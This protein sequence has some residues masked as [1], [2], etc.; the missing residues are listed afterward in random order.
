MEGFG[1]KKSKNKKIKNLKADN[2][3]EQIIYKAFKFHSEGNISE[4][5]KYYQSFIK[6][7][8][9]DFR[10]FSNYGFILIGLG[11]F[12]EA[13]LLLRK[14]IELKPDYAEAHLNLGNILQG[15]G[16]FKE[17]A[18][19]TH[20]A[21][22]LKPDFVIAYLN[23]GNILK[24]LGQLEKA[25]L[26]L[27]KAIELKP[28]FVDAHL[29]LGNILQS[30]SDYKEAELCIRKT[31]E[32]KPDY[33]EAYLNLGNILKNL[34][35]LEDAKLSY[36]KAIE[37]KPDLTSANCS[38]STLQY[39]NEDKIWRDQLFSDEILNKKSKKSQIDIYF[40]RANILHKE[41]KYDDSS[42]FLQLANNLKFDLNPF[43][44]ENFL[45]KSRTLLLETDK[46]ILKKIE[47]KNSP[48]NIF[49]VGM[50]R[51]GSTLLESIISMNNN[52]YAL[53]EVNILEESYLEYK[54]SKKKKR[55]DEL[56]IEKVN[57][58][59]QLNIT[60]NKW[61][62]NY[63]YAGI[64]SD[65]IP[66][67]KII[68]CYRNPLDNILSLYRAHFTKGNQYSSS[69]V[70]CAKVYL[71]QEKIMS[72]YKNKFQSKIYNLNYD[73][74]VS[75]PDKEIKSLISWLGWN[76]QDSYLSPH[77]NTR[78]IAT[79]S[80][81]EVRSPINSKSIGGWKNYREMLKPALEILTQS[82]K[83]RKLLS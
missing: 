21:I 7:G 44:Y 22:E 32:L 34:G 74:L 43:N 2:F 24:N 73:L 66:N 77:Q 52:V 42:K 79:R 53:G 61:L 68:H 60:T 72:I 20:K 75:N 18:I 55:I 37:L 4:A 59:T 36:Y 58:K 82:E 47:L 63:R 12:K 5:T 16:K 19:S 71:E 23:L 64:I 62:Y 69:L 83:Y 27:R 48:E 33:A 80:S 70:N 28:D 38:I 78:A 40:A 14:A 39:S 1:R 13:E 15:L 31:I 25:E 57:K 45:K 51:C 56:Y 9:K 26:Y 67:S 17:A 54:E 81:V 41:K 65:E 8:F 76:W 29:N 6:Q 35:K 49:I 3:K 30:L 50:P 11:K 10:V 46:K